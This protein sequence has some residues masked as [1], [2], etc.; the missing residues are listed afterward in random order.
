MGKS[1]P[2]SL[3]KVIESLLPDSGEIAKGD[4]HPYQ[5]LVE[6]QLLLGRTSHL[7]G[8]VSHEWK[9]AF[10]DSSG[11]TSNPNIDQIASL[12]VVKLIKA[13]WHYSKTVWLARNAAVHGRTTAFSTSQE[14]RAL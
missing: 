6:S 8:H 14:L 7:R 5:H 4:L 11:A 2:A 3:M 10:V 13:L 12:W 9:K 1:T